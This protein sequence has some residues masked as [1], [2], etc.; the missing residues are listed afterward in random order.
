MRILALLF[1]AFSIRH[2][3]WSMY[4]RH[5]T[6]FI[7]FMKT[8]LLV[9]IFTRIWDVVIILC[10]CG[11]INDSTLLTLAFPCINGA[12]EGTQHHLR[13][14]GHP[15]FWLHCALQLQP[16]VSRLYR[17]PKPL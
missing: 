15:T 13:G 3:G 14:Y 9:V 1:V 7:A 6:I 17:R 2:A 8:Y 10:F 5:L 4:Q 12:T 16:L 11:V